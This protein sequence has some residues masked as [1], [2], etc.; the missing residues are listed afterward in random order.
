M[1]IVVHALSGID[2]KQ[3]IHIA[4]AIPVVFAPVDVW[5][6]LEYIH[7]ILNQILRVL[8]IHIG[9]GILLD[10]AADLYE[11]Q[12]EDNAEVTITLVKEII[13]YR[14]LER[15]LRQFLGIENFV[16]LLQ[17][18]IFISNERTV[19][20]RHQYRQLVSLPMIEVATWC[21]ALTASTA[22]LHI[23]RTRRTSPTPLR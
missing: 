17:R 18:S 1:I 3:L 6:L 4:V 23:L 13:V 16:P 12:I 21:P 5:I 19:V 2:D 22:K 9:T 14:A 8:V 11:Y 7:N 10:I 15:F 20:E